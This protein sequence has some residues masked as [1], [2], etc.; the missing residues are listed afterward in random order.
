MANERDIR[1]C[2]RC[3]L[4]GAQGIARQPFEP[5]YVS[6]GM[7]FGP[8]G[9]AMCFACVSESDPNSD[10]EFSGACSFCGDIIGAA[11]GRFSQGRVRASVVCGASAMC[12]RCLQLMHDIV[13]EE[14]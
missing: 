4:K 7:V 6:D 5:G 13:E 9:L 3:G 8:P 2:W 10:L 1:S 14:T 11:H 12:S